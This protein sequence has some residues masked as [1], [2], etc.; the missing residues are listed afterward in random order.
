MCLEINQN[1]LC[2]IYLAFLKKKINGEANPLTKD[3]ENFKKESGVLPLYEN[4]DLQQTKQ[5]LKL[6]D[7]FLAILKKNKTLIIDVKNHFQYPYFRVFFNQ[8][9]F[10]TLKRLKNVKSKNFFSKFDLLKLLYVSP[11]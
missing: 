2:I 11:N 1:V 4:M 5:K 7:K 10:D 6:A 3:L 8:L 9:F